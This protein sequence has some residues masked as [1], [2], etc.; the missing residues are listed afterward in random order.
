LKYNKEIE[1]YQNKYKSL[2]EELET[3]RTTP[4]ANK[5]NNTIVKDNE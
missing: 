2:L 4:K 1:Q 3:K 5:K